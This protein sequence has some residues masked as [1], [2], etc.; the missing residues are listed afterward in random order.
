MANIFTISSE[1]IKRLDDRQARELIARLCKAEMLEQNL[2]LSSVT[3]GGDQRAKD[4]GVDVRIDCERQLPDPDFVSHENTAIQV[5]A[6]S[7]TPAKIPN[8]IA[9]ANIP[10]PAL[11]QFNAGKGGAYIIASTRDDCSDSALESRKDAIFQCLKT[12]GMTEKISYDFF[13]ARRIADWAEKYPAIV[14]WLRDA[15]GEPL[16]A[17]RPYGPWAYTEE[18]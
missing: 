10:R 9:P 6:E 11:V 1:I 7:F 16:S 14:T 5:K 3:W 2:P 12:H 8:E 4:G 13:D 17:W 15:I 18:D